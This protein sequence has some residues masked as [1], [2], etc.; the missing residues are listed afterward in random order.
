M[1]WYGSVRSEQKFFESYE[2]P[3]GGLTSKKKR[4]KKKKKAKTKKFTDSK[5]GANEGTMRV[6]EWR[7]SGVQGAQRPGTVMSGWRID[8]KSEIV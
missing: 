4:S 3:T 7:R 6:K 8:K 2:Y 1:A 5:F